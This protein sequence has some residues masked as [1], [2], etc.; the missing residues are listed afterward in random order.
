MFF[1]GWSETLSAFSHPE[2]VPGSRRLDRG[3]SVAEALGCL[4][5]NASGELFLL[6]PRD[7][8]S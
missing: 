8:M 2:V 6:S 3:R 1:G 4:L 5:S 7:D